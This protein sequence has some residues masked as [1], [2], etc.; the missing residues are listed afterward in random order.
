MI[1]ETDVKRILTQNFKFD[2][3]KI[4]KLDDFVKSL[5]IYNKKR[6]LIAKKYRKDIWC[7]HVLDSAQLIKFIDDKRVLWNSRFR[8]RR[9]FSGYYISYILSK[10]QFSRETI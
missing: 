8:I 3:P 5:L 4:K 2:A 6:N 9:G 10:F 7:R 1:S